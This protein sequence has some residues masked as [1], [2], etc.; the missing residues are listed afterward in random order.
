MIKRFSKPV[1]ILAAAASFVF[2]VAAQPAAQGQQRQA[3]K[4]NVLFIAIDDLNDWTGTLKGNPSGEDTSHGPAGLQ[5]DRLHQCPLR[6]PR[7]RAFTVGHHERDQAID[8][9]QL[10]QQE[11]A[12]T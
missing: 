6:R 2:M 7:V 10:H 11:F 3:R 1:S 9:R 5:R 8:F 12:D 4:P